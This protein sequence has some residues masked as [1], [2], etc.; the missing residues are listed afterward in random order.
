MKQKTLLV[1]I[2]WLASSNAF[3]QAIV[4]SQKELGGSRYDELHSLFATKDGGLIASRNFLLKQVGGED[5]EHKRR[6]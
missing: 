5:T 1:F 2:V 3:P 6:G 4:Q